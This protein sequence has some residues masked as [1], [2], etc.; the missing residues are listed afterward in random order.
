MVR[1]NG[2]IVATGYIRSLCCQALWELAVDD[3][4]KLHLVCEK[5]NTD[6]GPVVD[7]RCGGLSKKRAAPGMLDMYHSRCCKG[8]WQIIVAEEGLFLGCEK[9]GNIHPEILVR[10]T[11]DMPPCAC[12]GGEM[13][14]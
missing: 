9:C 14:S 1:A 8:H 3:Q 2:P 13:H 11:E 7:V 5:C 12:C 6:I 4:A 10:A